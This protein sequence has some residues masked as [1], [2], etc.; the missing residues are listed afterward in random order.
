M[1][2]ISRELKCGA[3]KYFAVF[4]IIESQGETKFGVLENGVHWVTDDFR[5]D[6]DDN[7]GATRITVLYRRVRGGHELSNLDVLMQPQIIPPALPANVLI[8]D[9][10]LNISKDASWSSFF[11]TLLYNI[12]HIRRKVMEL[13]DGDNKIFTLAKCFYMLES[14]QAVDPKDFPQFPEN[15]E[16]AF[17]K[18]ENLLHNADEVLNVVTNGSDT[19]PCLHLQTLNDWNPKDDFESSYIVS[20]FG[21][22]KPI[23]LS[24]YVVVQF[25]RRTAKNHNIGYTFIS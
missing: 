8:D 3:L 9:L 25:S 13:A 10:K 16:E 19:F 12:P 18:L 11:I 15:L 17:G 6:I 20:T 5:L 24:Q 2:I 22:D 23:K 14:G 21:R 4:A 1:L 7:S